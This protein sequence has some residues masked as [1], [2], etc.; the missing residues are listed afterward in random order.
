MKRT[1]HAIVLIICSMF[2][3]G[4]KDMGAVPEPLKPGRRDYVWTLDTLRPRPGDN[5]YPARIWG[6]SPND[7]WLA[8]SGSPPLLWHFDGHTWSHDSTYR[9][10]DPSALWGFTSNDIWLGNSFGSLWRYNGA[11]WYQHST[12]SLPGFDRI[13]IEDIWG[14]RPDDVWGVG[15]ADQFNGGT[16]YQGTI[17]H[18]DG[19]RWQFKPIPNIR[20]SFFQIRQQSPSGWYFIKAERTEQTSDSI[21]VYVYDGQSMLREIYS[22][23]EHNVVIQEVEGEVYFVIDQ[24]IYKYNNNRFNVWRD[25]DRT[26]YLGWMLGRTE[27]DFFALQRA[28]GG[29]L[30]YNGTD[31]KIIYETTLSV[32]L[33][34]IL[35]KDAYFV[36]EDL[37]SNLTVVLHGQLQ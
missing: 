17:I 1:T 16:Q 18:F 4:C 23:D 26:A 5:F 36:L 33:G 28:P 20:A 19:S 27:F 15:F 21:K 8:C 9:A 30:H 7:V 31:M 2:G 12:Y 13:A 34:F 10:I 24:R 22:S 32:W 29:I 3:A 14:A 11:Q 37:A 35:E 6:S 25:F